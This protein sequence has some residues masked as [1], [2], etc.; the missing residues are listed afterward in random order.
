M[1]PGVS[2]QRH[3]NALSAQTYRAFH[4]RPKELLCC[5]QFLVVWHKEKPFRGA[6][7]ELKPTISIDPLP[8][9]FPVEGE[10]RVQAFKQ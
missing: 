5:F 10:K 6:Q 4:S 2:F 7:N 9:A 3:E 1:C 8:N